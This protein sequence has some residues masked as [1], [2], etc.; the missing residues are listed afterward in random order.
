VILPV[1]IIGIIVHFIITSGK[2]DAKLRLAKLFPMNPPYNNDH[3]VHKQESRMVAHKDLP[4]SSSSEV[5]IHQTRRASLQ[6]GLS[7]IDEIEQIDYS[8]SEES[9]SVT[10]VDDKDDEDNEEQDDD[11]DDCNEEDDDEE[12]D[13]DDD[14]DKDSHTERIVTCENS[15]ICLG[16]ISDDEEDDEEQN[17]DDDDD[18]DKDSYD[19][20][21]VSDDDDDQYHG[22][23]SGTSNR[24]NDNSNYYTNSENEKNSNY[25]GIV[26]AIDSVSFNVEVSTDSDGDGDGDNN[27]NNKNKNES[28]DDSNDD[29]FYGD[30]HSEHSL[31]DS[32]KDESLPLLVVENSVMDDGSI[33]LESISNEEDFE[34]SS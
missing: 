31:I 4:S 7:V 30:V 3:V 33:W 11:D 23:G 2:A 29:N 10:S 5:N 25:G 32:M 15:S 24:D 16:S 22:S 28:G 14:D 19:D 6:L 17:D 21:S 26:S 1:C 34:E 12:E 27:V 13:D 20:Y 9:S 18:V 8:G